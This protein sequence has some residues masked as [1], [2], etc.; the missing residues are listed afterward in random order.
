MATLEYRK[1]EW[2]YPGD[3]CGAIALIEID[4]RKYWRWRS[5]A[6]KYLG[7]QE[8][9]ICFEECENLD[10]FEMLAK[11]HVAGALAGHV[12]DEELTTLMLA[13]AGAS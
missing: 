1:C 4:G 5:G 13:A 3:H 6:G 11:H 12:S 8:L 7:V 2:A 10:A 9:T